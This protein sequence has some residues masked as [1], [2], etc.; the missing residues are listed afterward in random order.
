MARKKKLTK[1][2][3]TS[4]SSSNSSD[5][6]KSDHSS[7]EEDIQPKTKRKKI[8]TNDEEKTPINVSLMFEPFSIETC[9]T[10]SMK[11]IILYFLYLQPCFLAFFTNS[12]KPWKTSLN[13]TTLK[14][15]AATSTKELG[16]MND[17]F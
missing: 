5:R 4:H 17:P 6:D 11:L 8:Q 10:G 13:K 2:R 12:P 3:S 9:I 15:E 14:Q 1:S 7:K 16:M